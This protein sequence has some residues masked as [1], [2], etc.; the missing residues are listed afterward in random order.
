MAEE[1]PIERRGA[2]WV[3]HHRGVERRFGGVVPGDLLDE[4]LG[5]GASEGARR[6]WVEAN[7]AGILSA[8]TARESGGMVDEP[9]GRV[10]V[11]EVP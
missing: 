3:V 11:E 10:L 4:E 2:D 8:V 5:D 9:W 1:T 6:D 7:L